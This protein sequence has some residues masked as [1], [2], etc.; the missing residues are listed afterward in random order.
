MSE[1]DI[2]RIASEVYNRLLDYRCV[3]TQIIADG[4]REAL[5]KSKEK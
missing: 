1:A 2:E 4:I 3:P 5:R